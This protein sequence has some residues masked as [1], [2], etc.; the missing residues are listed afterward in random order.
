LR[1]DHAKTA[2]GYKWVTVNGGTNLA[3]IANI[4]TRRE[5]IV[6]NKADNPQEE[7]VNIA[8]PL[9]YPDDILAQK[10]YLPKINAGDIL[11]IF[12]LGAYTLSSSTQFLYPR[13]AAVL[14][15]SEKEI[16]LIREKESCEDVLHK[17]KLV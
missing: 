10:I 1:V 14:V 2:G 9:L 4:F 17:D 16:K 12:D 6:A 11:A 3:P 13:P 8:G 5:I 15:N 7:L